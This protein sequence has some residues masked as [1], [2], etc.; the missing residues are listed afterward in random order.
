M[1]VNM[2]GIEEAAEVTDIS[3]RRA[4][5]AADPKD[6]VTLTTIVGALLTSFTTTDS[7][8]LTVSN[9]AH[10]TAITPGVVG[11]RTKVEH[12]LREDVA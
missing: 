3:S 8:E 5:S 1:L 12:G 9:D 10:V 11:D 7:S 4:D 6:R 2:M